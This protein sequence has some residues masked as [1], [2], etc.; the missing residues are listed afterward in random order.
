MKQ[1]RG[2]ETAQAKMA[3]LPKALQKARDDFSKARVDEGDNEQVAQLT[4]EAFVGSWFKL[5]GNTRLV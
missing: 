1:H 5:S 2:D 4:W 3:D